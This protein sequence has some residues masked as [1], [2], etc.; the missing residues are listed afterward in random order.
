MV[1]LLETLE[2]LRGFRG[3][4]CARFIGHGGVC[5]TYDEMKEEMEGII[6][7][8]PRIPPLS[9]DV[10]RLAVTDRAEYNRIV[11]EMVRKSKLEVAERMKKLFR[12]NDVPS[13]IN[14]M[15]LA[16]RYGSDFYRSFGYGIMQDP[17]LPRE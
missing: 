4:G 3:E 12:E 17:P 9:D 8:F 5:M 14:D 15:F 7:D 10:K 1:E 6:R 13:D 16:T 2:V 11:G